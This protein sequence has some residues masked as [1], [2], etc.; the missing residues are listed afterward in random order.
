MLTKWFTYAAVLAILLQAVPAPLGEGAV[1]EVLLGLTIAFIPV[2]SGIAIL[3]YRL[4]D[5]DRLINRTLVY[6]LLTALLGGVYAGAVLVLGQLFGG[7]TG[8]PAE[9]GGGGRHPGRGR[10]VPA[11]PPPYPGG[12]GSALQPPQVQHG[13]DHPGVLDPPTRAGR[14]RH[15]LGRVA[16]GR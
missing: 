15:P 7:V 9:L 1:Y 8:G 3:R 13:Q 16:G 14:P 10:P 4:Y 6:G 5:I 2:A 12:R 11:S